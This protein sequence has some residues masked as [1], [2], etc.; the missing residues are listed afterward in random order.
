MQLYHYID[1]AAWLIIDLRDDQ[2]GGVDGSV[3]M[4]VW[5][6]EQF[7]QRTDEEVTAGRPEGIKC[8][9]ILSVGGD[10]K[11]AQFSFLIL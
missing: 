10:Y 5:E 6:L 4:K 2:Q 11:R 1:S 7:D 3:S 9:C 8:R